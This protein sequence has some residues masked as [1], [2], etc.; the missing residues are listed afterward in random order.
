MSAGSLVHLLEVRVG[1][2]TVGLLAERVARVVE[3]SEWFG[4]APIALG[5]VLHTVA[6]GAG[7]RV[8]VVCKDSRQVAV[9]I[10]EV[11]GVADVDPRDVLPLPPRA[12]RAAPAVFALA[13]RGGEPLLLLDT[14]TL[15]DRPTAT[16]DLP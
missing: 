7:P 4:E 12:R 15:F 14:D 5:S 11:L 3:R 9:A 8:A 16:G 6:S 2:R 10:D 13:V 1:E